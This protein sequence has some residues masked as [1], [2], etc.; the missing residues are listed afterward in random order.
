MKEKRKTF[1]LGFLTAVVVLI[2]AVPVLAAGNLQTWNDVLVGG[3]TIKLNGETI[4][5]KDVNGNPVDPVIYDGTTYLPVRAIASALGLE[6]EWDGNTKTVYLEEQ[7]LDN[8]TLLPENHTTQDVEFANITKLYA[9]KDGKYYAFDRTPELCE[10]IGVDGE[11]DYYSPWL[12]TVKLLCYFNG[13]YTIVSDNSNP[14]LSGSILIHEE[15]N[16]NIEEIT[17]DGHTESIQWIEYGSIKFA[18]GHYYTSLDKRVWFAVYNYNGRTFIVTTKDYKNQ[19]DLVLESQVID[20]QGVR[21]VFYSGSSCINI[22]DIAEFLGINITDF[23]VS[24]LQSGEYVIS[25]Q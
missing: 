14:F 13:D 23:E 10:A 25:V 6:V 18:S 3:I 12:Q 20:K 21:I 1:I 7:P 11:R 4:D 2:L 5:P 24:Q 15:M 17:I 16:P 19:E 9:E 8:P 22:K